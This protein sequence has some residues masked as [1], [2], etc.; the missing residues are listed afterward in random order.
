M[1]L[2][3]HLST[4]ADAVPVGPA[5]R[6]CRLGGASAAVLIFAAGGIAPN[7]PVH[8]GTDAAV[9]AHFRAHHADTLTG[10][11]L[12]ALALVALLVFT[13]A[14]LRGADRARHAAGGAPGVAAALS[15]LAAVVTVAMLMVAQA[16]AA[17]TA[18]VGRHATDA[19]LLRAL[20]DIGHMVAHLTVLPF[21]LFTLATGLTLYHA[22]LGA[23]WVA[24][25]GVAVGA[26]M[27]LSGVWVATGGDVVHNLGGLTWLATLLWL[28][29]QSG[30]LA[31][32]GR[33]PRV[34]HDAL[35]GGHAREVGPALGRDPRALAGAI[36]REA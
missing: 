29:A 5:E 19:G 3:V 15:P 2:P 34:R 22:R 31:L 35:A 8:G 25:A 7:P 28:V 36:P 17:A 27:L 16:G 23:R 4:P 1:T 32:A 20:D 9:L 33:A 13:A 18:N 6:L 24:G 14:A 30:T 21:G 12:W 26:A 10:T 11:F